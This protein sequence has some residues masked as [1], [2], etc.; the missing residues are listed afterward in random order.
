[1]TD[2]AVI[3]V[4]DMAI[5]HRTFRAA[6]DESARLVRAETD[7]TPDRVTFLADHI[8]FGLLLLHH[9]HESEDA[10]LWPKLLE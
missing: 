3:E 2:A 5:V 7:P 9:H 10:L 4:R 8:D 6:Y 1:M